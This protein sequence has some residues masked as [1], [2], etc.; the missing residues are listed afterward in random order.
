[1][2]SSPISVTLPSIE[3]SDHASTLAAAPSSPQDRKTDRG[4]EEEDDDRRRKKLLLQQQHTIKGRGPSLAKSISGLKSIGTSM[5]ALRRAP[6][7]VVPPST[8]SGAFAGTEQA[9]HSGNALENYVI[10]SILR[11][12]TDA[13]STAASSTTD[14]QG[15]G[16]EVIKVSKVRHYAFFPSSLSLSRRV[17]YCSFSGMYYLYAKSHL[18]HV[19][20]LDR[21][22][23][24]SCLNSLSEWETTT[25]SARDSPQ[26]SRDLHHQ[27]QASGGDHGINK[28]GHRR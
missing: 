28:T 11:M 9:A 3:R 17:S 14:H 2:P 1:M 19:P 21:S 24:F 25:A 4:G 12:I 16:M 23:A 22:S 5:M 26:Q 10:P 8:P 27:S 6:G 18:P 20:A 7:D 15:G 13:S